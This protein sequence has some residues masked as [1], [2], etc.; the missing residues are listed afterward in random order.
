[1]LRKQILCLFFNDLFIFTTDSVP[2]FRFTLMNKIN[3][4]KVKIFSV[5]A[6]KCFPATY[7]AIGGVDTL[8]FIAQG[9]G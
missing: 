6:K 2:K 4:R 7:V 8:D 1:M 5:P 3:T 9:I